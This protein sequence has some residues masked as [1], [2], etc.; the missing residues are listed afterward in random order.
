MPARRRSLAGEAESSRGD[1]IAL[2]AEPGELDQ[3][4]GRGVGVVMVW[5]SVYCGVYYLF[6]VL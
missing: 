4:R 2:V 5:C 3:P 1:C 6:C